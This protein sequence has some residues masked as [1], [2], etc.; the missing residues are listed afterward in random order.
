MTMLSNYLEG[1]WVDHVL[2]NTAYTTPG[3][4]VYVSLHTADTAED[5][6]GTE[7]SGNNYSRV[8]VTSWDAPASRATQN[9]S[10]VT[11][12]TPSGSWGTCTHYGIWDASTV[13]NLLFYGALSSSIAPTSGS[14]VRFAAGALDLALTG[15]WSNYLAH[16]LLSHTLRNT[17]YTTPGTSLYCA[18][19]TT[20]PTASTAGTEASGTSYARVQVS[21]WDAASNG[22]TANTSV[23][24]F[25]TAGGSWGTIAAVSVMDASTSGN[26]LFFDDFTGV[27]VSTGGV[28]SFAAGDID[29]VLA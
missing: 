19:Y 3:T 2:R 21:T 26:L 7:V 1:K 24:T 22:A 15:G 9:T 17:A 8:Q 20:A 13:G 25:P 4:S 12:P 23:I 14:T 11:F 10:A 27:A 5:G 18:L 28:F 6:S 16:A 29:I